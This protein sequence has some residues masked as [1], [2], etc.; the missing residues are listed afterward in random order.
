[1][2]FLS[3]SNEVAAGLFQPFGA[4]EFRILGLVEHIKV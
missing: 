3:S 4:P 2:S 1:M